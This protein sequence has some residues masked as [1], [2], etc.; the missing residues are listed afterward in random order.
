MAVDYANMPEVA[1]CLGHYH[2]VQARQER[3]RWM[4]LAQV[5]AML[6][7]STDKAISVLMSHERPARLDRER[8]LYVW[9][10]GDV[11]Q[12]ANEQLQ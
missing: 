1:K 2:K 12:I 10:R 6:K 4:S 8:G 7:C 9:S 3:N 5:A 11:E